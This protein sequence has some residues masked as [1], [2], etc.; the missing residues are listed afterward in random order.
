MTKNLTV[1]Y[2][3]QLVLQDINLCL[4]PGQVIGILGPNGAGKSTLLKTLMSLVVPASGTSQLL[5][6]PLAQVRQQVSYVPQ[7]GAVDWDF[8][9]S[10]L[11]VVLMGR[12][13]RLGL[14]RWPGAA[15]RACAQAC[16]Q[17]VGMAALAQRPI[18]QL[19]GGQ[20][21]RVL[22]ARAL[23]QEA[24]LY[25]M[26]EPFAAVDVA[27]ERLLVDLL[28]TMAQAGKSLLVVHHDLHAVPSYFAWSVLLNQRLVAAGPTQEVFTP[29]LLQTT[30]SSQLAGLDLRSAFP[31]EVS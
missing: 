4:P 13:P 14:F 11:D 10:V 1:A 19:S 5:G 22:L 2:N 18:G 25:L 26:D 7:K 17:Q 12:Y 31:D 6:Q 16:L 29:A 27:T 9:A 24:Q 30:Y 28:Q 21:Q 23:A 8:P 15:D 3:Q 20:Q